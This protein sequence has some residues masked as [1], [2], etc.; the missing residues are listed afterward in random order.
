MLLREWLETWLETYIDP[1]RAPSTAAGYRQALKKLPTPFL[2]QKLDAVTAF[3]CQRVINQVAAETPRQAQI[4]L[5]VLRSA[6]KRAQRLGMV[7]H[8]PAGDVEAP[9]HEKSAP[10]YLDLCELQALLRAAE[11]TKS[12]KAILLMAALGLRR[13]EALGLCYG[14]LRGEHAHITRQRNA[15]GQMVPLKTR[16]SRRVLPVAP[17]LRRQLG[18]GAP[19]AP[20]CDV[21]ARILAQDLAKAAAEAG[22]GHVTP[23][24]LRHTFASQAI[25]GGVNMRL[26]QSLMGHAHFEVTADTYSHVYRPD[27]DAAGIKV[28]GRLLPEVPRHVARLEIV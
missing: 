13:G 26:L 18:T 25:S 11:R 21:S 2:S 6:L 9:K 7:Q 5:V 17:D 28:C 16:A 8:N 4:C 24:M 12:H 15:K 3:D 10:K 20:V 1:L 19:A 14:D 23:H 22:V 27:L